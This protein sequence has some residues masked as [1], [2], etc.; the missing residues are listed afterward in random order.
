VLVPAG[1]L[2][3]ADLPNGR[4]RR[5]G[6]AGRATE[7]YASP[8]RLIKLTQELEIT[9]FG[10]ATMLGAVAADHGGARRATFKCRSNDRRKFR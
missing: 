1:Q 4:Q 6:T 2:F 8:V 5:H 10:F 3:K 9:P 7:R